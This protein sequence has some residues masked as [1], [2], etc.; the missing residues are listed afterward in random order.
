MDERLAGHRKEEE[1]GR[2][3]WPGVTIRRGKQRAWKTG[4]YVQVTEFKMAND[5]AAG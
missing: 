5:D 1:G 4:I 2:E 3:G